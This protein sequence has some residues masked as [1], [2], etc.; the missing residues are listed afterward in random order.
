MD[1]TI[2]LIFDSE[3]YVCPLFIPRVSDKTLL[4][5]HAQQSHACVATSCPSLHHNDN[6]S[7]TDRILLSSYCLSRGGLSPLSVHQDARE[8]L[9]GQNL[10]IHDSPHETTHVSEEHIL[11]SF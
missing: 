10:S 9:C 5:L 4:W 1:G 3:T 2:D 8:F 11:H 6:H 7:G